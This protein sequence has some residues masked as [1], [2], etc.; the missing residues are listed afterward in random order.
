MTTIVNKYIGITHPMTDDGN[1]SKILLET[2]EFRKA[3]KTS[4]CSQG[5]HL[6]DEVWSIEHHYLHCDAC[7]MEVHIA[8]VVIP[9]GL[10]KVIGEDKG[11]GE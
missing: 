9:D 8:K 4:N 10:N 2:K 6:F 3:W 5:I 7:G 1:D 11:K